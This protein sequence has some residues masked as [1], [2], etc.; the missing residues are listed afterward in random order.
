MNWSEQARSVGGIVA[1]QSIRLRK[2]FMLGL[3]N[4]SAVL[5]AM[6]FQ[7]DIVDAKGKFGTQAFAGHVEQ[8]H[9]I[10]TASQAVAAA[11]D[12]GVAVVHVKVALPD[13][14]PDIN[15]SAPLF[16]GVKQL[17][18]LIE[19]TWGADFHPAMKPAE[20]ELII[21]KQSV[22]AFAGTD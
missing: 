14:H 5:L 15:M 13:G 9:V 6:D 8:R 16:A 12:K 4:N 3:D 19:G 2:D 7:N 10:E 1:A 11:R 18:A 21:T 17:G 20:G 22:S